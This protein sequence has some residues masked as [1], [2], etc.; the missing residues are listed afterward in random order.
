M[1][2]NRPDFLKAARNLRQAFLHLVRLI[3]TLLVVRVIDM[4]SFSG[5]VL[6]KPLRNFAILALAVDVLM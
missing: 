4:L 2:R 3:L 5:N 1:R 6:C